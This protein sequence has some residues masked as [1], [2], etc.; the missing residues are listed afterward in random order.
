MLKPRFELEQKR[1]RCHKVNIFLCSKQNKNKLH[2]NKNSSVSS[3]SNEWNLYVTLS[4]QRHIKPITIFL[5]SFKTATDVTLAN[6]ALGKDQKVMS[7]EACPHSGPEGSGGK[8]VEA[9]DEGPRAVG[10]KEEGENYLEVSRLEALVE[11]R[12]QLKELIEKKTY[13]WSEPWQKLWGSVGKWTIWSEGWWTKLQ[14]K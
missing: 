6:Q 11:Q 3:S 5:R 8:E 4:F 14:W 7:F 1:L 12:V 2:K 13:C 10:S 9:V